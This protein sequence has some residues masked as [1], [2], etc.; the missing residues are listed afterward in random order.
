MRSG[1]NTQEEMSI[2]FLSSNNHQS[3][4]YRQVYHQL[5]KQCSTVEQAHRT[6]M[7]APSHLYLL[8]LFAFA[9]HTLKHEHEDIKKND[10]TLVKHEGAF[11]ICLKLEL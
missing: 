8:I 10:I 3:Y 2:I 9:V 5:D 1:L 7:G 6:A 4:D 11:Q